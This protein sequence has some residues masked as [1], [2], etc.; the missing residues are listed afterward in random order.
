MEASDR[1]RLL[2]RIVRLPQY[3]IMGHSG[4][5]VVYASTVG[6]TVELWSLDVSK[7]ETSRIAAG[8]VHSCAAVKPSS[9]YAVYTRDVAK[10]REQQNLYCVDVK[11]G[12]ER[13]I[14]DA[15][16]RVFGMA[17]G[18]GRVAFTGATERDVAVYVATTDGSLEKV[19]VLDAM[20]FVTDAGG[21][22]VVGHGAFES[23]RSRELFIIDLDAGSMR[24]YTP[25]SGSSNALPRVSGLRILFKSN[26]AGRERLYLYDAE[27]SSLEGVRFSFGDYDGYE[28]VEHLDYGWADGGIW[29][30]GKREGRSRLFLDGREVASL[31]GF[32][33]S[34]AILGG[35][36]YATV[37]SLKSPEK[38][39]ELPLE[40]GSWRAV[41]GED[42]PEDLRARLGEVRFVRYTS[43][44][45][46]EIPMYVVESAL[47]KPGP[48]VVY[49][50]GGPWSEVAD[51]WHRTIASLVASGYHVVAPN[52]RGST[53]YGEEFRILDI[54][55]PGGGDLMDVVWARNWALE[56]GLASRVAVLGYSYGG[57]ITYLALG[58]FPELWSCGVAGAGVVDRRETYEMS[59]AIFRKFLDVLFAGRE[60]LFE[61][62]SPITY[63]ANVRAPL[64]ILHPQND[65]RT[66]LRPVLR[67][68]S[69]LLELGKTFEVHILPDVGHIIANTEDALRLLLPAILFLDRYVGPS[70]PSSPTFRNVIEPRS[71]TIS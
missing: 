6:G 1:V 25:R 45:G 48:T 54:G 60:E 71:I 64:C 43:F 36:A 17:I 49:V 65:T 30:I 69:R 9:P 44:D 67:Y 3:Q 57:Y 37:S 53:G 40:G 66:P 34:A 8:P 61:E 26:F 39:Y 7:G 13:Q 41:A 52:F 28:P 4:G 62:R 58:R 5:R 20:A 38:I 56:T 51:R 14:T 19:R 27:T 15:P 42:L 23:P 31:E 46:L 55:D 18:D 29:A 2:E 63:V 68:V 50:H 59:D 47:G 32:V 35:V 22:L 11:G 24:V 33:S 12:E 21:R 10:G 16:M 70:S